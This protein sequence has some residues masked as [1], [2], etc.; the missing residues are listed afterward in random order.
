MMGNLPGAV[1]VSPDIVHW[2]RE[3]FP[4]EPIMEETEGNYTIDLSALPNTEDI[5][6]FK[7]PAK[8]TDNKS[9]SIDS[10]LRSANLLAHRCSTLANSSSKTVIIWVM[11]TNS[12]RTTEGMC[13]CF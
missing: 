9:N 5:L 8:D 2:A 13:W 4:D 7:L 11:S 12:T 3:V 1:F 10:E 6:A